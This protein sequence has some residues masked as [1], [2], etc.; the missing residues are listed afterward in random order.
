MYSPSDLRLNRKSHRYYYCFVRRRRKDDRRCRCGHGFSAHAHYRAGSE[1]SLCSDCPHFRSAE[2]LA[3]HL[4]R[5]FRRL[6]PEPGRPVDQNDQ[7][8]DG[9]GHELLI[10]PYAM[11]AREASSALE[12]ADKAEEDPAVRASAG[13]HWETSLDRICLP[14][15]SWACSAGIRP[16]VANRS[17]RAL[18]RMAPR[19]VVW[20][21]SR[22]S[23]PSLKP[24]A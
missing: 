20:G 15:L 8:R 14:C 24:P 18:G 22:G 13:D 21:E 9:S 11:R 5:F 1:C 7:S 17:G 2:G 10:V 23:R 19:S 6:R 12:R 3:E 4:A 16:A